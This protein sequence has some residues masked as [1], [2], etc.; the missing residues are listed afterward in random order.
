MIVMAV[1]DYESYFRRFLDAL[2]AAAEPTLA[3][4]IMAAAAAV[5]GVAAVCALIFARG[6]VL[7]AAKSR[8]GIEA[9]EKERLQPYIVLYTEAS[10]A[11][12][13]AIDIVIKNF[14]QT[15]AS[16]VKFNFAKPPQ[17]MTESGDYE[18]VILPAA[19]PILAPG[20]EWRTFWQ[21]A[22]FRNQ[23]EETDRYEGSVEF[24]G[25]EG[26]PRHSEAILDWSLYAHRRWMEVLGEHDSA[27]ALKGIQKVIADWARADRTHRQEP[28]PGNTATKD[29]EHIQK[30]PARAEE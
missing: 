26:E 2:G 14:G 11:T 29:V 12:P 3:D 8:R 18:T 25:L 27:K 16:E 20:Q 22:P 4:W 17:R 7:E 23:D 1:N 19:I 28:L 21:W 6:Q 5:A 9:A 15:A 10:K 30:A 24:R 13:V